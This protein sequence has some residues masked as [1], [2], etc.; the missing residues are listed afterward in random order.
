[1]EMEDMDMEDMSPEEK[2]KHEVDCAVETLL[3]ADEIRADPKL[4][5]K[6]AERA[7]EKQSALKSITSLRKRAGEVR[8]ANAKAGVE[9]GSAAKQYGLDPD[10]VTEE[11]KSAIQEDQ[12]VD[13]SLKKMGF[14]PKKKS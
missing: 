7:K 1:M 14:K 6:V 11:D 8:E 13:A 5:A 2:A 4:M 9:T 10:L 3:K 12:R